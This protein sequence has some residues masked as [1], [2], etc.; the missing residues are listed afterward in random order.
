MST[1][2]TKYT[3]I[4]SDMYPWCYAS[5]CTQ[6]KQ[7]SYCKWLWLCNLKWCHLLPTA[8]EIC[9]SPTGYSRSKGPS[10]IRVHTGLARACTQ[11]ESFCLP[12]THT[13]TWR[14]RHS[15]NTKSRV[16]AYRDNFTTQHSFHLRKTSSFCIHWYIK[17]LY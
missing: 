3:Q 4:R 15:D 16:I 13:C 6:C 7:C 17:D 5:C 12:A 11:E 10:C 1:P 9:T 14:P 8:R 2:T